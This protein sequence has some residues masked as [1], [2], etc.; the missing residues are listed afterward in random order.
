MSIFPFDLQMCLGHNDLHKGQKKKE[1]DD[2]Q[3]VSHFM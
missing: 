1:N 2:I 3:I